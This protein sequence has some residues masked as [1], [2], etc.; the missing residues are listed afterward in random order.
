MARPISYPGGWTIMQ[1]NNWQLSRLHGHYSPNINNSIGV[2]VERYHE[3]GRYNVNLQWNY[4]LGRKNTK[5]SQANLYLKTQGGIAIEDGK[6]QPNA[7]IGIAGDWETRR[8][9]AS[10]EAVGRYAGEFNAGSFH[11]KA[12][13]GIAPYV[14]EYGGLH[15]WIM[16]QADHN[17]EALDQDNRLIFTPLIRVFKGDY[18]GEFGVNTNGDVMVN[19]IVRF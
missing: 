4:L 16:V 15:L 19:W 3:T 1:S 11:H 5:T 10:Y 13:I 8:Y 2:A 7:S 14:A 6:T 9:F 18:L 17:L 12:R